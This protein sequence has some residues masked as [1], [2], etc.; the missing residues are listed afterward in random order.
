[1][2]IKKASKEKLVEESVVQLRRHGV[3]VSVILYTRQRFSSAEKGAG[4]GE[5]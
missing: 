2:T 1:M 3:G 5:S 4:S